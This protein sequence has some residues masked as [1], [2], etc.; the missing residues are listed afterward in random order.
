[1]ILDSLWISGFDGF[2]EINEKGIIIKKIEIDFIFNGSY[3]V[4]RNGE[5]LFLRVFDVYLL[6][7]SG[8]IKNV[9]LGLFLLFCLY[10][11]R[12]ND[13]IFVGLFNIVMRYNK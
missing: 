8:E 11:F 6:I 5:L 7:I 4:I 3:I 9:C 10:F 12:I 13:D 1:M 2:F